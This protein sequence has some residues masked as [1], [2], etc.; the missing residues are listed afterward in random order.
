MSVFTFCL[1]NVW[2]SSGK[3]SCLIY[4]RLHLYQQGRVEFHDLYASTPPN[5][6]HGNLLSNTAT[7]VRQKTRL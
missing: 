6:F 3:G 7:F 2:R 4:H 5:K 1:Q